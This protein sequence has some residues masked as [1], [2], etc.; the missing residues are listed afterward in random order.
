MLRAGRFQRHHSISLSQ[1]FGWDRKISGGSETLRLKIIT[2]GLGP[3]AG[4]LHLYNIVRVICFRKG[5]AYLVRDGKTVGLR[6]TVVNWIS[7]AKALE[8]TSTEPTW[9][10]VGSWLL[11][12]LKSW[13][14]N[15]LKHAART[16][17]NNF[18]CHHRQ[19]EAVFSVVPAF[20][21]SNGSF[22]P[23][24]LVSQCYSVPWTT[25]Q[26]HVNNLSVGGP[27]SHLLT[28]GAS[29]VTT[30]ISGDLGTPEIWHNSWAF[31]IK[32]NIVWRG[33]Y[34]QR[35]GVANGVCVI[36]GEEGKIGNG[37]RET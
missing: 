13:L 35:T 16:L 2:K 33:H 25:L 17:L 20:N 4:L 24:H 1:K 21:F 15:W 37:W 27:G 8:E 11:K 29:S 14:L 5:A 26:S 36:D 3:P 7:T 12:W 6:S 19:F 10:W 30:Q 32:L 23:A 31:N 28:R 34:C 9:P 22:Y 18:H